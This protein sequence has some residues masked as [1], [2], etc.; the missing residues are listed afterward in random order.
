MKL[1]AVREETVPLATAMHNA[2]VAFD[3]MTASA[4]ALLVSIPGRDTP[5]VGFALDS[6]GRYAKGGLLRERLIPRLVA[7][8]PDSWIDADGLPDPLAVA[9]IVMTNEKEGG[10]GERPG[11]VGLIEAAVWDLRAKLENR[12]LWASIRRR[13]AMADLRTSPVIAVYGSCGHFRPG[14]A[15]RELQGLADEVRAAA[16][17]G[18]TVVKIKLGGQSL[19]E[20]LART[21]AALSAST[22]VRIAVDVN[23]RLNPAIETPWLRALSRLGVAWIEEPASPLDYD[24]LSRLVRRCDCPIATGENLF[25]FDDARNLLRYGGL[26]RECDLIQIDVSLSYGVGHYLT[27]LDEFTASGWSRASFAPHAGHLFAA[28]VVAGLGLGMHEAATDPNALFAGFW[29]HHTLLAGHLALSDAPG[30]GFERKSSLM[31]R[32]GPLGQAPSH[33]HSPA[34]FH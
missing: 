21:E 14:R 9:Q 15:E 18:H 31:A 24:R 28:H 1:L 19:A 13:L 8:A 26:R 29:D 3:T 16:K 27:I 10:H 33:Q 12:P 11:A 5:L 32:L 2:S 25:S 30:V 20:D 23:G 17:S 22:G 7:A 4:L 6:I 34:P